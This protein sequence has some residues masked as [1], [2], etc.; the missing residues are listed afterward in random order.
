M[1]FEADLHLSGI[2]LKQDSRS[3]SLLGDDIHLISL[4]SKTKNITS[5]RS[6]QGGFF[7]KIILLTTLLS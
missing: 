4:E 3:K 6:A 5:A 1:L 2:W 7:L